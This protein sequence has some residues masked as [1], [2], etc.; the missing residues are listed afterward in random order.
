MKTR[1]RI[2]G[3]GLIWSESTYGLRKFLTMLNELQIYAFSS[4]KLLLTIIKWIPQ[5][6]INYKRKATVGFAIEGILLD[7]VGALLSL[8]QLITDAALGGDW[9]G[10]TAN[11][12][13]LVLGNITI[14]FDLII[15][16]QHYVLYKDARTA[17]RQTR[18]GN[19]TQNERTPL[20]ARPP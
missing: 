18:E 2:T 4:T 13:K 15:F 14:F 1:M 3:P 16:L 8:T 11:P 20:L 17:E 9:S 19:L 6:W 5:T 12:A 10:I 7:F